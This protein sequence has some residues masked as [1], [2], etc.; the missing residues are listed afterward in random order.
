MQFLIIW[1]ENLKTEIPWYLKRLNSA[2][3]PAIYVSA[4]L[5]FVVPFFV[6]LWAPPKYH[7]GIVAVV[8]VSI[9]ISRV[10]NTWLLIMPE[11]K[12]PTPFWLDI[13]ALFALGG[14]LMLLFG[15][16][17]RYARRLAPSAASIWTTEHG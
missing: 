15:A 17:L 10:A 7:R 4:G 11:F 14:L 9:L 2:W 8:C 3:E 13:A 1:E 16:A 6:L 12:S 5:G